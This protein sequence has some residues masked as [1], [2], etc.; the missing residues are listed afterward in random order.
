MQCRENMEW[1][2]TEIIHMMVNFPTLLY[3]RQAGK[4]KQPVNDRIPPGSSV[5]KINQK[6]GGE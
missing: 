4:R 5:V 3:S 2:K 6:P 1:D